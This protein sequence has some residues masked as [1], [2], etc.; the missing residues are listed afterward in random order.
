MKK[1][2][3]ELVVLV[4]DSQQKIVVETLLEVRYQALGIRQL[5]RQ[6]QFDI[7]PHPYRDPGVYQEAG[8]FLS[9]FESQYRYALVLLDAEWEGTPGSANIKNSIQI[10]LEQTGWT[11]RSATIVIEPELEI[12]VWSSSPEVSNVLGKT[13]EEIREI[14]KHKNYWQPDAAKPHRPKELMDE[15]L[16][17]VRKHRSAALFKSLAEKVSLRRCED[18]AFQELKQIL[19]EWFPPESSGRKN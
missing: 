15:V 2:L 3:K 5:V 1:E 10:D 8:K 14:A 17:Q 13:S 4:A 11:N 6:E 16:R 9:V 18:A 19:Q 12:W 7:Y